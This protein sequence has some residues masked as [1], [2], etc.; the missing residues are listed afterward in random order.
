MLPTRRNTNK[1]AGASLTAV[2]N[3]VADAVPAFCKVA[4]VGGGGG[5]ACVATG[6]VA[7]VSPTVD[8]AFNVT[9]RFGVALVAASA[10]AGLQTGASCTNANAAWA[11][12]AC[13][14]IDAVPNAADASFRGIPENNAGSQLRVCNVTQATASLS[15]SLA[16]AVRTKAVQESG[17]YEAKVRF[18]A[19]A[20]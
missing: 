10:S 18:T 12:T 11:G 8:T 4:E 5:G 2:E 3:R 1:A 17:L 19:A 6:S 13:M 20:N 15:C 9:D 16:F 7:N 14:V